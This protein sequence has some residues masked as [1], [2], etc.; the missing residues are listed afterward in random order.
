MFVVA[1]RRR[2]FE[3]DIQNND[4]VPTAENFSCEPTGEFDRQAA[5][6]RNTAAAGSQRR[7]AVSS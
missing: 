4:E 5:G 1:K 3:D 2:G 6:S 7:R